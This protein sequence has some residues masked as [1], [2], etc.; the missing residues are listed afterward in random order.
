MGKQKKRGNLVDKGGGNAK[1]KKNERRGE[2]KT[3]E[4]ERNKKGGFNSL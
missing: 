1:E 3:R 2:T 4:R